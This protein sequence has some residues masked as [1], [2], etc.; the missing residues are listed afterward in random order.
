MSIICSRI[1]HWV[2]P[3]MTASLREA[4]QLWLPAPLIDNTID[5]G[6][7]ALSSWQPGQKQAIESDFND[8]SVY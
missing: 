3:I 6:G 1:S 8:L 7:V 5:L 4:A 2:S